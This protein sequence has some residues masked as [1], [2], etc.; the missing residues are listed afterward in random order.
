M[1]RFDNRTVIVTEDARLRP[2]SP[3]TIDHGRQAAIFSLVPAL[4]RPP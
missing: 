4:P 2:N 1:K 3:N